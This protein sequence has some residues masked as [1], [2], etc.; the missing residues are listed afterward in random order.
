MKGTLATLLLF[1]PVVMIPAQEIVVVE[2]SGSPILVTS[3]GSEPLI[4]GEAV[5]QSGRISLGEQS[6]VLLR[7]GSREISLFRRGL[8]E[9]RELFTFRPLGRIAFEELFAQR[10][11]EVE[12]A[13]R[14]EPSSSGDARLAAAI[15][16]RASDAPAQLRSGLASLIR[17]EYESAWTAFRGYLADEGE[18]QGE[19]LQIARVLAAQSAYFLDRNP[20]AF[21]LLSETPPAREHSHFPLYVLLRAQLLL[22]SHAFADALETLSEYLRDPRGGDEELQTARLQTG[23]AYEGLGNLPVARTYYR[24]ATSPDPTSPAARAARRLLE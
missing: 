11:R 7:S 2:V 1:L 18:D 19:S 6:E 4:E 12:E 24:R 14:Q 16:E 21:E 9:V 15:A 23:V 20:E 5:P 3:E 13:S 10:I 22:E 17:G 8:Y